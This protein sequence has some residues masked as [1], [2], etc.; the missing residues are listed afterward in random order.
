MKEKT[1]SK[2]EITNDPFCA[3]AETYMANEYGTLVLS[4]LLNTV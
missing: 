2:E 4:I 3:S 1:K